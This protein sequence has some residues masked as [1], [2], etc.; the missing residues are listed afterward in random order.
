MTNQDKT[1]RSQTEQPQLVGDLQIEHDIAW[2]HREW[3]VERSAWVLFAAIILAAALGLFGEGALS[4]A[5]VRD[6]GMS[7]AYERF[8][9]ESAP[10]ELMLT[11]PV[12][13]G[14]AS[15]SIRSDSA[16]LIE[17]SR[18]DPRPRS[19][20]RS[21]DGAIEYTI[22]AKDGAEQVVVVMRYKMTRSGKVTTTLTQSDRRLVLN[23]FVYP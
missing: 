2:L 7:A 8:L 15:F 17:I 13:A 10:S 20:V 19:E 4:S 3:L 5:S 9:R 11:L 1:A 6:G 14:S 22:D 12:E 23:Q 18:I 16:L 21:P